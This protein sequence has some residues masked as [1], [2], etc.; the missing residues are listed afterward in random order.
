LWFNERLDLEKEKR[1]LFTNSRK[2]NLQGKNQYSKNGHTTSRMENVNENRNG[3]IKGIS[4]SEN[5]EFA[6]LSD[7][8]KQKL[9]SEQKLLAETGGIT[10]STIIKGSIY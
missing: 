3:S 4:F 9:G 1:K 10:P 6:N 5:F 7:G 2:N 8:T